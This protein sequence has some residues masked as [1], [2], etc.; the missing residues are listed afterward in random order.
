MNQT[1][2]AKIAKQHALYQTEAKAKRRN[3]V[4]L[5]NEPETDNSFYNAITINTH[6]LQL[7]RTE[8]KAVA[9]EELA[10]ALGIALEVE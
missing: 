3:L 4:E 9:I 6:T 8:A 10:E 5:V 7:A 1:D 2:I